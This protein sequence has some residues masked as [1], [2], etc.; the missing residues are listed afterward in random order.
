MLFR[1]PLVA[2][3]IIRGEEPSMDP[4]GLTRT[5][6]SYLPHSLL[7]MIGGFQSHVTCYGTRKASES[8]LM[9]W[10]SIE[11]IIQSE[12]T[13][14]EKSKYH[15]LMH[16]FGIWKDGTDEPICRAAVETQT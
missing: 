15:I 9:R 1:L 3:S 10:M 2:T 14:K 11:P 4:P 6:P 7:L 16:I 8:V 5:W 13:Q 12:V